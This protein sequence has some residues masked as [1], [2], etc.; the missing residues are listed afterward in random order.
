MDKVSTVEVLGCS[1]SIGIPGEGTTSFLIDED[2]LVDA[3]TGLCRLDF[4]RL[5]KID[6]VLLTHSHL[7]HV[8]GLPF[9]VDTVGVQR[10][11]PL[12]V[13]ASKYTLDALKSHVFNELI[14]PDFSRI[15]SPDKPALEFICIEPETELVF[16]KRRLMAVEV[17]HTV[18]GLGVFLFTPT[19]SWCFSG[20]THQTD[21]LFELIN[22]QGGV[23]YFFIETAFS[24]REKWL[25]DLAKHLSPSLLEG[26]LNKLNVNCEIWISHLKPREHEQICKELNELS[27]DRQLN[28]LS[29][30]LIFKV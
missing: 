24:E 7:D 29:S 25:A 26:E 10:Q 18:P 16:G 15:P 22:L 23:D 1:G 21:R 4:A 27:V 20:D 12:K 13:Y 28:I 5:E 8:C 3:G 11:F 17:E 19:G 14:W 30:G 6:H 9:L 2:I